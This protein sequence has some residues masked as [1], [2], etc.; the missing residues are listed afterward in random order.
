MFCGITGSE[1]AYSVMLAYGWIT[2]V[3]LTECRAVATFFPFNSA[4]NVPVA[5]QTPSGA[6][7][8]PYEAC[9]NCY[10]AGEVPA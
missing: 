1:K 6:W 3:A 8:T 5:N 10:C 4:G 9:L 7:Q 2:A